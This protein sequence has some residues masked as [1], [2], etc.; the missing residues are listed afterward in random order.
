MFGNTPQ[1]PLLNGNFHFIFPST[2]EYTPN[3]HLCLPWWPHTGAPQGFATLGVGSA[4]FLH[5]VFALVGRL[6]E[7]LLGRRLDRQRIRLHFDLRDG[8]H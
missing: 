2:G 7:E 4:R 6:G 3:H 8:F 1:T 5:E